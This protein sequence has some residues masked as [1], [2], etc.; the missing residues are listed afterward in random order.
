MLY[1]INIKLQL[2]FEP[3]K[4]Y[5]ICKDNYFG[6]K[7]EHKFMDENIVVVTEDDLFFCTC[8]LI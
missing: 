4:R 5:C 2:T 1:C 3:D 6:N 8:Y 7:C